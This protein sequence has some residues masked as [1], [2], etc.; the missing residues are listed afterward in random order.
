MTYRAPAW[1]M[2]LAACILPLFAA[3]SSPQRPQI[4]KV[5]ILKVADIR[6]GM[7]GTAWTVFSG[8]EPDPVPIEIIGVW[9]NA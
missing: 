8:T 5:D 6:P 2:P 7:Q 3:G 4:G 9:K 1:A